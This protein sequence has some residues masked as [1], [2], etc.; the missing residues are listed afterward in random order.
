MV[1]GVSCPVEYGGRGTD[2][3]KWLIFEEE[4]LRSCAPGRASQNGIFLLGRVERGC[5]VRLD[6]VGE[7]FVGSDV[8]RG[9]QLGGAVTFVP[10]LAPARPARRLVWVDPLLSLDPILSSTDNTTALTGGDRYS[11]ILATPRSRAR[12]H[13]RFGDVA[14]RP[15]RHRGLRVSMP[16]STHLMLIHAD[17]HSDLT[18]SYTA[19][20]RRATR[21]CNVDDRARRCNSLRTLTRR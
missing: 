3:L 12:P 7:D 11:T 16:T 4:Y 17:L 15:G 21:T 13:E 8:R 5:V 19:S 14:T 10:E 1:T 20:A 6:R 9:H 2:Y 18:K